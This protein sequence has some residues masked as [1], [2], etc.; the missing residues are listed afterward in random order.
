MPVLS[1]TWCFH[2]FARSHAWNDQ[3]FRASF[4]RALYLNGE[5]TERDLE[6]SGADGNHVVAH[7]VALV[8]AG[9]F[10]G[11]GA[12]PVRWFEDGWRL[13][14]DELPR[15]A[16]PDG[17]DD[18]GSIASHALVLERFFL[19]A[20]Y[21]EACGLHVADDYRDRVVDMARF[22]LAHT[23]PEGPTRL[24]GEAGEARA[25]PF[26]GQAPGDYRYLAGLVGAHWSISELTNGFSGSRAEVFWM[27][28]ARAAASLPYADVD[29]YD[30]LE[31]KA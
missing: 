25:L 23:R 31:V 8:F 9:L 20:R 27:L 14:C 3:D 11:K 18:D 26:G 16:H 7:A 5:C 10:F 2:V 4:L 22:T 12:A 6:R 21:R 1:W 30:A 29:R 15:Y 28:G 24:C 13:L 19:A 17:L